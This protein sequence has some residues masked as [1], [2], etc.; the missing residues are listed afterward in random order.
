MVVQ[1]RPVPRS[2]GHASFDGRV[3]A[4]NASAGL[5]PGDVTLLDSSLSYWDST[6]NWCGAREDLNGT[7]LTI[8]VSTRVKR[9]TQVVVT[10]DPAQS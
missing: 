8:T 1:S 10:L 2:F 7:P 6:G 5:A 9:G 4:V 3:N